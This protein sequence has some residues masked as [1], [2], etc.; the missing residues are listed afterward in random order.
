MNYEVH[1]ATFARVPNSTIN[2][3]CTWYTLSRFVY[4]AA[5]IYIENERWSIV[6]SLAWWSGNASCMTGLALALGNL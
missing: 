1:F 3:I 6:R 4:G 2:R 5:Y